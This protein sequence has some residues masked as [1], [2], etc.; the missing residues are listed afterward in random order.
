MR[1]FALIGFS[2]LL[3]LTAAVYFGASGALT[4]GCVCGL[5]FCVLACV[6]KTRSLRTVQMALLSAA[7]AF[8]LF[9]AYAQAVVLPAQQ[10]N[11]RDAVLTGTVCELPVSAY[12]RYYYVIEVQHLEA[13]AAPYVEKVRISAQNALNVEPYD[14]I[15]AEA[16]FYTPRG[17]E[18]FDSPSY[19]ASKGI[20]LFGY[21]YEYKPVKITPAKSKPPYLAAL[22]LRRG[23]TGA[24]YRLLPVKQAGLSAGVLLG[25]TSGIGEQIKSDF[26]TTGVTHILSV[27]GL[28]MTTMAQFFLLFL[29]LLRLPRR[30][31]AALAMV[32]VFAFM[33]V[34]G[35]VPSVLRSGIMSLIYLF[36]IVVRRQAD[37]LNS[38][39][40][41]ALLIGSANPYAAA[42]LGLLLSFSATLGMILCAGP[43]S[44]R[45]RAIYEAVPV[46]RTVLDGVNSAVCTTITATIFT[47]P[48]LILS[49]G[50]VSLISPISNVMQI[51]PSTLLMV[52]AAIGAGL[53]VAGLPFLAM[54]FAFGT[55]VLSNYM[56]ECANLLGQ[57]PWASISASYGFVHL[58]LAGSLLLAAVLLVMP[59]SHRTKQ[60]TILLSGILLLCGVFS[61]QLS[62][63]TVTR[64]AVLQEGDGICVVLTHQGHGAVIG[65]GGFQ[66]AAARNYLQGQGVSQLDYIQL[67]SDNKDEALLASELVSYFQP[68]QVLLWKNGQENKFLQKQLFRAEQVD[69]YES[70][71][72]IKLW[73]SILVEQYKNGQ[74]S[75]TGITV[76]G[77]RI[78]LASAESRASRIPA[79]WQQADFVVADDLPRNME[80]LAPLVTVLSMS[81]E[82]AQSNLTH[83]GDIGL[84]SVSTGDAGHV[85]IDT[86]PGGKIALRRNV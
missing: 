10:M 53:Y 77:V 64:V 51:L 32:G 45:L 7:A 41:A 69:Y 82:T 34:T 47:L 48:I 24:L 14:T 65:C 40:I 28:H 62:M 71:A 50:T 67:L 86:R 9:Y 63:R 84:V 57:V 39:G 61:Y 72:E 66:S 81:E 59:P 12:G 68:K 83:L 49:F 58:W 13:D 25:D 76:N 44:I 54:P 6:R 2:Y 60:C 43:L 15:Q 75:Y 30:A 1:P 29:G 52:S 35:F 79:I 27:S 23:M 80:A 74:Q 8:G 33:A 17:G 21:L 20:T 78:L 42:D 3:A 70:K 46:G 16:H 26:Q 37:S 36:G 38:L 11:G 5:A 18:G 4:M 31:G 85:I 73:D 22:S 55:G 56:I 19:Y